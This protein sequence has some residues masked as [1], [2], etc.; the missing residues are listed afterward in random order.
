MYLGGLLGDSELTV[1]KTTEII[2]PNGSKTEG[3]IE[4]PEPRFRQ[5]MV[6]YAGIVIL[7]GGRYVTHIGQ[8]WFDAL[9]ISNLEI[10]MT[11]KKNFVA[12]S[13]YFN[14]LDIF[15]IL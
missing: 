7:M 14:F 9:Y 12:F 2:Y 5:C 13:E 8:F 1:L 10:K 15:I 6:E 11:L 4:L 3:P